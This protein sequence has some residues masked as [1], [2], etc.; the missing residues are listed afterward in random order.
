MALGVNPIDNSLNRQ[1]MAF[2]SDLL[3]QLGAQVRNDIRVVQTNRQLQ[4]FA[5]EV[6]NVS[7]TSPEFPREVV[8]LMSRY[9]LATMSPI[10]QAAI[11]QLGAERKFY[12]QEQMAMR[13][14]WRSAGQGVFYNQATGETKVNDALRPPTR[15]VQISRSTVAL[16][17]PRTGEVKAVEEF[18]LPM[19]TIT[20]PITVEEARQDN[21]MELEKLRQQG[22]T[23]TDIQTRS[24]NTQL[25]NAMDLFMKKD[26]EATRLETLWNNTQQ[27][28]E[29][30]W[31]LGNEATAA[32]AQ[33]NRYKQQVEQLS[34]Q[35]RGAAG[36]PINQLG[37]QAAQ[38]S[39]PASTPAPQVESDI[40]IPPE[41]TEPATKKPMKYTNG[42]LFIP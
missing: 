6:Q 12:Q 25:N 34:S 27:D 3:Q 5:Q 13:D 28:G 21:R 41:L 42:Q 36:A 38:P 33:A 22:R 10:G 23:T 19:P 17:D 37:A 7:P 14:P 32:R 15:P 30:K 4:G 16:Q 8:G 20:D 2:Q 11:N 35:L 31:K 9:P 26:S 40:L 29:A 18:G 24:I 39:L 1:A